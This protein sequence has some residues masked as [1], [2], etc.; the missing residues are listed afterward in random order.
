MVAIKFDAVYVCPV[1]EAM[2]P[3]VILSPDDCHCMVPVFPP[4]VN[5]VVLV[6]VQTLVAPVIVPATDTG[7]TV[8][9]TDAVFAAKQT[10]LVTAA[11]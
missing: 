6:P 7:F 10:P 11:R 1:A 4:R 9:I 5:K 3:N 2:L 8:I